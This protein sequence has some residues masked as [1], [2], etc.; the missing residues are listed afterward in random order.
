VTHKEFQPF[1]SPKPGEKA[2]AHPPS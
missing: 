1:P 2:D